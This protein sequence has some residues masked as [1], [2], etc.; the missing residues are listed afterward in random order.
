MD[1]IEERVLGVAW[2]VLV[3]SW[4]H[5]DGGRDWDGEKGCELCAKES[6]MG[7]VEW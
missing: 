2:I 5:Q 4:I 7:E 3:D 1:I 6:M